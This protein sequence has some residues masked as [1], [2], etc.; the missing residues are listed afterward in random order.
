MPVGLGLLAVLGS[1]HFYLI[2][3]FQF[4]ENLEKNAENKSEFVLQ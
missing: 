4:F 1:D 2:F 3:F